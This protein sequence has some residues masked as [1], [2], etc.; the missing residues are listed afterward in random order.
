MFSHPSSPLLEPQSPFHSSCPHLTFPVNPLLISPCQL[1]PSPQAVGRGTGLGE[2]SST[3]PSPTHQHRRE[4]RQPG[5]SSQA[6]KQCLQ[7]YFCFNSVHQGDAALENQR[8]S[9]LLGA[10]ELGTNKYLKQ[11]TMKRYGEGLRRCPWE[12][13]SRS[14]TTHSKL[15]Q[16]SQSELNA[17]GQKVRISHQN[18][19]KSNCVSTHLII[20]PPDHL[21]DPLLE[22]LTLNLNKYENQRETGKSILQTNSFCKWIFITIGAGTGVHKA[23]QCR[24]LCAGGALYSQKLLCSSEGQQSYRSG[25]LLSLLEAPGALTRHTKAA[26]ELSQVHA[27]FVRQFE[28]DLLT[29]FPAIHRGRRAAELSSSK[30]HQGAARRGPRQKPGEGWRKS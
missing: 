13:L 21:P 23:P 7:K 12:E 4:H 22:H 28:A 27:W 25:Q 2:L 6:A 17:N 9:L 5:G 24:Q 18:S 8:W 11:F 29:P 19:L 20:Y 10:K 26:L 3:T 14:T 16:S 30:A 15:H 1:P